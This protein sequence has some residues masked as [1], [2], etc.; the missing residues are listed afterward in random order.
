[1]I[2]LNLPEKIETERLVLLRLK[3]EDAEEIFYSY[4]SKPEVTRYLAFPTHQSVA[5]ARN[6]LKYVT[7]AWD[8]G[9]EYAFGIRLKEDNRFIGSIGCINENGKVQF[10]Y[11]LSP[12]YWNQGLMTE[13]GKAVLELLKRQKDIYRIWTFIDAENEASGKVLQ[14][15][16][17]V[18]EAQLSKWFRFVNQDNQPKDCTLYVLKG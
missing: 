15:C 8:A 1:M 7:A 11:A 17:L 16:G 6:F 3:Y 18:E 14:K 12:N 5:D 9:T 13:A 2:R 10:G 4:A